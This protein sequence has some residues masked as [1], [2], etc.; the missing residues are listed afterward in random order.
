MPLI[1][2]IVSKQYREAKSL[3]EEKISDILQIRLVEAK[4]AFAARNINELS[5]DLLHRYSQKA[6]DDIRKVSDPKKTKNRKAGIQ[7]VMLDKTRKAAIR[8]MTK[9][10]NI[11]ES[12]INRRLAMYRKKIISDRNKES[13]K[14]EKNWLTS[15]YGHKKTSKI[16]N[17]IRDSKKDVRE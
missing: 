6:G 3:I 11:D 1:D 8:S 5:S 10:E 14:F 7:T 16:L 15:N 4:K 17:K 12:S 13:K 2:K 9:E